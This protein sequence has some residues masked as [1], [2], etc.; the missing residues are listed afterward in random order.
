MAVNNRIWVTRTEPGAT[1]L[2]ERLNAAMR[3]RG[4]IAWV[5]P[6][7]EVASLRPWQ[8]RR[9]DTDHVEGELLQAG[10]FPT[11]DSPALLVVLSA[12]AAREY[13]ANGLVAN[14]PS[15]PH[16]AIGDATAAVLAAH[17]DT[18]FV[19]EQATSEGILA[20]LQQQDSG[21]TYGLHVGMHVGIVAGEHGRAVLAAGLVRQWQAKVAQY[22]VYKRVRRNVGPID[23]G[24]MRAIV[25]ASGDGL[26]SMAAQWSAAGGSQTLTLYVPSAR[27]A[28]KARELG[29]QRVYNIGS[30]STDAVVAAITAIS[31]ME[32]QT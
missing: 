2:G 1:Q 10:Q 28:D 24:S 21:H 6:V 23:I 31:G 4:F 9:F 8:C 30:A 13:I 15:V 14:F 25:V 12:H 18:V 29:F 7:L 32:N 22:L 5:A 19:P 27:V 20:H 3:S 11:M 26:Q 17:L 16:L